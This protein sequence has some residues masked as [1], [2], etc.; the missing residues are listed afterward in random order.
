M[1]LHRTLAM[2]TVLAAVAGPA[3]AD[4]QAGVAALAAGDLEVAETEFRAAVAKSP[5]HAPAHFMLGETLRRAGRPADAAESLARA[6]ELDPGQ[7]SYR[8][9]L[10]QALLADDR[11]GPAAEQL[12]A[13]D[14]VILAPT[15]RRSWALLCGGALLAERRAAE[16]EPLLAAAVAG[17]PDDPAL[18]CL[19][20]RSLHGLARGGEAVAA[21]R[22]AVELDPNRVDCA[23]EG[24]GLAL[25][26]AAAAEGADRASLLDAAVV[27]A[28]AA[29][30]SE[31]SSEHLE[32]AG[33]AALEARQWDRASTWFERALAERPAD[34]ALLY[35]SGRALAC[36]GRAE[37]ATARLEAALAGAEGPDLARRVRLQLARLAEGRADLEAAAGLYEQTG[38]PDRS[39]QL[40]ELAASVAESRGRLSAMRAQLDR[41]NEQIAELERLGQAEV[42]ARVREQVALT[43]RQAAEIE[44][45]LDEVQSTLRRGAGCG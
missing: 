4:W 3:V 45:Y 35:V 38:N 33:R 41:V 13:V 43:E 7:P 26:L 36:L 6:V 30:R 27:L 20:A 9:V 10:A 39:R 16:A 11:A 22:R 44:S 37:A 40:L 5:G 18:Q 34:P 23:R 8:L 29:A 1:S 31:P 19:H 15:D 12:L 32:L 17:T 21:Y 25:S 2:L 28:E 24:A 14:P 42:A